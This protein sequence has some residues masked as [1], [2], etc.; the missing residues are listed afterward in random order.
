M[1]HRRHLLGNLDGLR[2]GEDAFL[3]GALEVDVAD[4]LAEVRLGVDEADQAVLNNKVD[5][6]AL[7][8][9]LEDGARRADNEIGAPVY[10]HMDSVSQILRLYSLFRQNVHHHLKGRTELNLKSEEGEKIEEE[11]RR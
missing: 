1:T 5:I 2:D 7:L 10:T 3:D 11:K 4:L 8:D 6:G 9:R